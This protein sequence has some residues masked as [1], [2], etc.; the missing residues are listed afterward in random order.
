MDFIR[1]LFCFAGV[2]S[3]FFAK[4]QTIGADERQEGRRYQLAVAVI[5]GF[6]AALPLLLVVLPS[7][8]ML[9]YRREPVVLADKD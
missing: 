2:T 6:L 8:M 1:F 7:L 9:I 5:G 3:G 4:A